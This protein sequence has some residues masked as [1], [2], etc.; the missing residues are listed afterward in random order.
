MF[1]INIYKIVPMTTNNSDIISTDRVLNFLSIYF[2]FGST[3]YRFC[4][5][6]IYDILKFSQTMIRLS[7]NR[8]IKTELCF[9]ICGFL[10]DG[11]MLTGNDHSSLNSV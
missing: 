1:I 7:L 8:P 9:T 10:S 6:L 3:L 5:I 2:N 11:E 4:F